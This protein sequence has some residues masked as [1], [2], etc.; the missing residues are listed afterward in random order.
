[1]IKAIG[2]N[3]QLLIYLLSAVFAF[4]GMMSPMSISVYY[5]LYIQNDPTLVMQANVM[6]IS[7]LWNLVSSTFGPRVGTSL[8]RKKARIAGTGVA[9]V[10]QLL[11][12]FFG[13]TSIYAFIAFTCLNGFAM[14]LYTGFSASYIIDVGN[15]GYWKTKVDNRTVTNSLVNITM[16]ISTFIRGSIGL[17]GLDMIGFSPNME[18]TSEFT[19]K[20]MLLLGGLPAVC[21][22]ITA[23][24]TALL[25]KI[26]DAE[27]KLYLDENIAY[28]KAKAEAA[29]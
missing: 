24:M 7:T 26:D 25:Y 21:F 4:I 18:V 9:C 12:A 8:G 19:R 22:A 29:V 10:A 28:D 23:I 20:Y 27:A 6:L 3:D 13:H 2:A 1:M 16:K 11:I 14:S 5:Y 17:Y 15:Y